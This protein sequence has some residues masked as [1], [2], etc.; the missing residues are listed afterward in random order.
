M[1][2]IHTLIIGGGQAGLAMSRCL[3]YRGIDHVV[4][5]RGQVA[6]RWSERWNSLRLLSPNW[7]TRL[8]GWRYQGSKRDGF[9]TRDEVIRYLEAY[10]RSFDAPV[11][12]QTTVLQVDRWLETWRV[13]TDRETWL[14]DNVVI[15]TGHCQT[16][17][18]PRLASGL[19]SD[20]FQIG[21]GDYR[22]PNQL[23]EGGVLVV[24]A[25]ASGVQLAAELRRTGRD[26][27]LAVG[28]H[29][30][31]PRRY[32]GR[33]I[34][35]WLDRLGALERP[36]S[37]MPDAGSASRE[38][39]L[40]LVG[41]DSGENVDLATLRSE[42]IQLAGHLNG[43]DGSQAWFA[44]DLHQRVAEA[45]ERLLGVLNRIDRHIA[46]HSMESQV[47][48]QEAVALTQPGEPPVQLDLREKGIRSV[49]W[50]T[51]YKRDYSWLHAPVLDARGEIRQ[52]R[53]ETIAPGLFVLG[54][55]FM[56]RRNSSFIDGVGRDAEE[57]AEA[58]HRPEAKLRR[59]AA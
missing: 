56:I 24:G 32:R 35:Y 13:V 36:L 25:S 20:V 15:A 29:T 44:D 51:G 23:P 5:E 3:S 26:V 46:A 57:I 34:L 9:M 7:M 45:D 42:G 50:A 19:S 18:I 12:E 2:R 55:Q 37:D 48:R 38:A 14:A 59:E 30:R 8:P 17:S 22:E 58:I 40:Q 1:K 16:S 54:L 21:T 39:S 10:A 49:L 43:L 28:R 33:D 47:G 31:L 41:S 11:Q 4:L 6:Q 27:V 53:G 52:Q